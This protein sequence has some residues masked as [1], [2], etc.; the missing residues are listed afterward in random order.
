MPIKSLITLYKALVMSDQ[1]LRIFGW[2]H[3]NPECYFGPRK[4]FLCEYLFTVSHSHWSRPCWCC[5]PRWPPSRTGWSGS[6][7]WGRSDTCSCARCPRHTCSTPST[8]PG[9]GSGHWA[10][11]TRSCCL[12]WKEGR[13]K[14]IILLRNCG[15]LC[16]NVTCYQRSKSRTDDIKSNK[17]FSTCLMW[18]LCFNIV[19][20]LKVTDEWM[21]FVIQTTFTGVRG[22]VFFR[23]TQSS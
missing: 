23:I 4:M 19:H 11:G 8:C 6:C 22:Q 14:H 21:T 10:R 13:C 7:T 15:D 3:N 18:V 17:V 12:K 16:F 20:R 1:D 2:H 5:S 9:R